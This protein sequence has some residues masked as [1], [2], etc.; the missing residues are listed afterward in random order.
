MP[1][2]LRIDLD[3]EAVL[4]N[5]DLENAEVYLIAYEAKSDSVRAVKIMELAAGAKR[6]C[7]FLL[8][9]MNQDASVSPH[10][11]ERFRDIQKHAIEII[12]RFNS[13]VTVTPFTRHNGTQAV[14][15][16]EAEAKPRPK[17]V[18][19]Q[20]KGRLSAFDPESAKRRAQHLA[21]LSEKDVREARDYFLD[22]Q[23]HPQKEWDEWAEALGINQM[24]LRGAVRGDTYRWVQYK[25]DEGKKK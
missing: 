12:G 11:F 9:A 7:K 1:F 14:V 18:H 4:L 21:A 16:G 22:G 17:I 8:E 13:A 6:L 19:T 23:K 3:L 24:T 5:E 10:Q 15:L 25:L 2:N 20:K